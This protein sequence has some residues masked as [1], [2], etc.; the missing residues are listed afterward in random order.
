MGGAAPT[1]PPVVQR[2]GSAKKRSATGVTLRVRGQEGRL[3]VLEEQ[4]IPGG[5]GG[6]VRAGDTFGSGDAAAAPLGVVL[7]SAHGLYFGARLPHAQDAIVND[8]EVISRPTAPLRLTKAATRDAEKAQ[9]SVLEAL[10]IDGNPDEASDEEVFRPQPRDIE[11]KVIKVGWNV[12]IPSV[13]V[14]TPLGRGQSMLFATPDGPGMGKHRDSFMLEVASGLLN[15]DVNVDTHV[16]ACLPPRTSPDDTNTVLTP[17]RVRAALGGRSTLVESTTPS[18]ETQDDADV[19][20]VLASYVTCTLAETRRDAG[21]DAVLMLPDLRSHYRLWMRGL[22]LAA[23]HFK[24]KR[25]HV[26]SALFAPG[27]DRADLRQYYS[28]LIQRSAL[29]RT[30]GSL[31]TLQGVFTSAPGANKEAEETPI[32]WAELVKDTRRTASELSRLKVLNDRGIP[33]TSKN[34]AKIGIRVDP[35]QLTD[36]QTQHAE[37]LKSISDGHIVMNG[38][39]EDLFEFDFQ[40]SLTRIGIGFN[41]VVSGDT[42]PFA[43]RQVAGPLRLELSHLMDVAPDATDAGVPELVRKYARALRHEPGKFLSLPE[44]VLLVHAVAMGVDPS[45]G[46]PQMND[47]LAR[48]IKENKDKIDLDALSKLFAQ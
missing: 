7:Y 1:P 20:G 5:D 17:E 21:G 42:R 4:F 34:L 15:S 26:P 16:W 37:E 22:H 31:S 43:L 38:Q 46:L 9:H 18:S 3:M 32:A 23:E 27:A 40:N 39:G 6:V 48:Q 28:S 35:P 14:L 8:M 29:L 24:E 25:G 33:L 44:E 13:D 45:E 12:G 41:K 47:D 36:L 10:C 19:L 30:G 2:V 11:R